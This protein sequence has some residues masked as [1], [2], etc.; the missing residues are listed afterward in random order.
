MGT[1]PSFI[2]VRDW[3]IEV[4]FPF[5][6]SDVRSATRVALLG[7]TVV[8]NLIGDENP[9][10]KTLRINQSPFLVIG[11]L[12]AKGQSLAGRDQDDN[13]LN[14][15]TTAQNRRG[16]GRGRGAGRGG[17]AGA[18]APR[19]GGAAGRGGARGRR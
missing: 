3:R 1:T 18:G 19:A 2:E 7:Q 14:P 17:G 8:K 16:G 9:V 4:G 10:G 15:V 13:M 12:A 6:D 11:E 5:T